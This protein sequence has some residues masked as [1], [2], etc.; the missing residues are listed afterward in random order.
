GSPEEVLATHLRLGKTGGLMCRWASRRRHREAQAGTPNP[1]SIPDNCAWLSLQVF[2]PEGGMRLLAAVGVDLLVSCD[3]LN[4]VG[5]EERADMGR[6]RSSRG[7]RNE[8][9]ETG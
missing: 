2:S 4:Q 8:V 3:L 7:A 6:Q 5:Q 9:L 1:L